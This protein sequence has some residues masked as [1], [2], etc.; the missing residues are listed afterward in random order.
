MRTPFVVLDQSLDGAGAGTV[1]AL[2]DD[3]RHHLQR[4]L[5]RGDG[6]ELEVCDGRGRVAPAVLRDGAVELTDEV[7]TR[8]PGRPPVTVLHAVPKGR[9]LDEVVRTLAEL[10]VAS[11]VPVLTDRTEARPT[12]DAAVRVTTRWRLIARSAAE[13]A[14][15]AH[16]C[17]ISAPRP[18]LDAI[19]EPAEG[20]VDVAAEPSAT[21][22]LGEALDRAAPVD[23]VRLLIGPEGGLT[24]GELAD[25]RASA[26]Q[27]ARAGDTVLR[28]V[29]AATV[30]VAATMALTGH[31]SSA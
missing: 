3:H 9:G 30:L 15:R 7:V 14:R 28:S 31:Y 25:L 2:D 29:H 10:G 1:V 20:R 27:P 18:L 12:G 8:P 22:T 26:W 19:G 13:Q 6:A 16:T 17:D 24:P 4:V 11:V 23:A 5:R 21:T